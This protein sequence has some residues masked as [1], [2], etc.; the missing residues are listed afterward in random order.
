VVL[1]INSLGA[2]AIVAL[3]GYLSRRVALFK[4]EEIHAF[5]AFV[6]YFG[7]PSLFLVKTAT[8]EPTR[9]D[10][11]IAVGSLLPVAAIFAVLLALHA[12]KA[13]SRERFVASALAVVFGSN[14]FF[15]LAFFQA[16]YGE[17]ELR[18]P[19]LAATILG[20]TGVTGSVFLFEYGVSDRHSRH[21]ILNVFRSPI[22]LAVATGAVFG[23]F[24]WTPAI[25]FKPL[26]MLG[27]AAPT[28]AVFVLG[29]FVHDHLERENL[30]AAAPYAAL[31]L[32]SLPAAGF[33]MIWLGEEAF[34]ADAE[35]LFLQTGVPA[36]ISIAIF[37]QRYRF[38]VGPLTGM[39]VLTSLVSFP[40]LALL[41]L[42]AN[43]MGW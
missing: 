35:F 15:G 8:M 1:I 30:R 4:H 29:M 33:L 19:V 5:S 20:I 16:L 12:A 10:A 22:V 37:A 14:A 13:L 3:F 40:V 27:H 25:L 38:M 41:Y 23:L 36:A 28:V 18:G 39:V 24:G 43:A 7:L 11:W 6:Y 9:H 21:S 2:L 32:L 31:R 26:G 34:G 42:A 17:G